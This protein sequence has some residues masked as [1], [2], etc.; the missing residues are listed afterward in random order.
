MLFYFIDLFA[1][2]ALGTYSQDLRIKLCSVPFRARKKQINERP[3]RMNSLVTSKT[4]RHNN[5][6]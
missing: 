4:S 2:A 6:K 5:I 1:S 3:I